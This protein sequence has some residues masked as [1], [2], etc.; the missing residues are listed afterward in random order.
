MTP[1][2][3][4]KGPA[5]VRPIELEVRHTNCRHG[6]PLVI[7][8]GL[9]GEFDVELR[10]DQLRG[11]AVLLMDIADAAERRLPGSFSSSAK[12]VY[13]PSSSDVDAGSP[14]PGFGKFEFEY[15]GR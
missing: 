8:N 1:S 7:V 15:Q 4:V 2:L 9:P 3:K 11:Y 13:P 6:K 10:P 5:I 12:Y 14:I